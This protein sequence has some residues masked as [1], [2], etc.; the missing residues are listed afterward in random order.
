MPHE[1]E[2]SIFEI[3]VTPVG[4]AALDEVNKLARVLLIICFFL[5]L[6][7]VGNHMV[8]ILYYNNIDTTGSMLSFIDIKIFPWFSIVVMFMNYYQWTLY[9]KFTRKCSQSI[10]EQ[11]QHAFN[12]SFR[13]MRRSMVILVWIVFVDVIAGAYGLFSGIR[14]YLLAN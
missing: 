8:R 4:A 11:D 12:E 7:V 14:A 6:L 13:I 10:R 5:T 1:N 9:V 3:K 2:E